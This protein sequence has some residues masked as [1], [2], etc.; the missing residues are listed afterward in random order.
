LTVQ[1]TLGEGTAVTI[2]L[3]LVCAPSQI[4]PPES[5]IATLTPPPRHDIQDQPALVKKSA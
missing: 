2:K 4:K 1:S 3:P 5:K